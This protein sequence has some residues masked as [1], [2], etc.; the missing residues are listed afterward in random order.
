VSFRIFVTFLPVAVFYLLTRVADPWVAVLGGFVATAVVFWFTRRHRLIGLLT[1]FGFGV[2]TVSAAVGIAWNNEKAYLASGP[3]SDF[4]FVLLYAGSIAVKKPLIGGIAHEL[5]PAVAGRIPIN[6][7]VFVWLSVAWAVF[8]IAHGVIRLW[9]LGAL[10]VGEYI[11][12]SRLVFWPFSG[13][14]VLVSFYA[15]LRE[16]RIREHVPAGVP[17]WEL[18][19]PVPERPAEA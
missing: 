4:L 7:P 10:G 12:L 8:D 15:V 1:L 19:R 18:L 2:V 14:L 5:L 6:A 3:V 13:A 16:A 11:I 9:M 17:A